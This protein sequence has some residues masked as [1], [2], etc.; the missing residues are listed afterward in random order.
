MADERI[1]TTLLPTR[2]DR[3]AL[4]LKVFAEQL[5]ELTSRPRS[6][7][8]SAAHR[9]RRALREARAEWKRTR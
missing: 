8:A 3:F 4:A 7:R 9:I 1:V 6:E 5:L 2:R